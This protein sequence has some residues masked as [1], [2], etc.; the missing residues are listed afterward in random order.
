MLENEDTLDD[1]QEAPDFIQ[2]PAGVYMLKTISGKIGEY[3]Y[4][5]D[6]GEDDSGENIQFVIAVEETVELIS[7]KEPPV[8]DGS[9][10]MKKYKGTV[11][12]VAKCKRDFR[13]MAGLDS[14]AGMSFSNMFDLAK[15]GLVFKAVI[16]YGSFKQKDGT[17]TQFM[18]L[19]FLPAAE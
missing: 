17:A 15:E 11:E 2:P 19:R 9:L 18:K 10:F 4:T 1:I 16:S 14:L 6:E 12:D 8:P 7:D 13:K 5:S 3:T